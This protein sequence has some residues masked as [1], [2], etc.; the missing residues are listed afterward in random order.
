MSLGG[1]RDQVI[2]PDT[3]EDM[4]RRGVSDDE[5]EGI[6]EIVHLKY[7]VRREGGM[8]VCVCHCAC[9]CVS[10][11]V[12]TCDCVCLHDYRYIIMCVFACMHVCV[13]ARAMAFCIHK[14]T[15]YSMCDSVK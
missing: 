12:C 13:C 1:L 11:S 6:L 8:S 5:L 14:P 7:I 9:Q 2:Y 3:V 10:V 4:E 15:T